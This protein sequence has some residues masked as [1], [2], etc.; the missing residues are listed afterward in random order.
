MVIGIDLGVANSVMATVKKGGV[1][2]IRNDISERVTPSLVTYTEKERIFGDAALAQIKSNIKTTARGFKYLLGRTVDDEVAIDTEKRHSLLRLISDPGTNTVAYN[3]DTDSP[4]RGRSSVSSVAALSGFLSY[5][6]STAERSV[7]GQ[8]KDCVVAVPGWMSDAGRCAVFDAAEAAGMNCLKTITE[9]GAVM[10][11]YGLYRSTTFDPEKPVRVAF[12]S[13]GHG[14]SWCCIAEFKSGKCTT[15]SAMYNERLGGRDM[16]NILID[17]MANEFQK[18]HKINPRN[19]KKAL[20]KLEDVA[21]KAKKILSA[22]QESAF[23]AECLLEECDLNGIVKRA[24]FESMCKPLIEA[25][26]FLLKRTLDKSGLNLEDISSVEVVGGCTRIPF[27]NAMIEDVFGKPVCR[28]L[29]GDESVA[30]GAALQCAMMNANFKV[31]E[32]KLID[33]IFEDIILQYRSHLATENDEP[34]KPLVI[35]ASGSEIDH[36]RSCT[37]KHTSPFE[38]F[39]SKRNPITEKDFDL[40]SYLIEVVDAPI[41]ACTR[42]QEKHIDRSVRVRTVLTASGLVRVDSATLVDTFE[43]HEP[44]KAP[45]PSPS[46]SPP[47]ADQEAP[48]EA[49]KDQDPA[50]SEPIEWVK[51]E[52]SHKHELKFTWKPPSGF[53]TPEMKLLLQEEEK[54]AADEDKMVRETKECMND[55]ESYAYNM[56]DRLDGDLAEFVDEQSRSNIKTHLRKVIDWIYDTAGQASKAAYMD[57]LGECTRLLEPFTSRRQAQIDAEEAARIAAKEAEKA[58]STETP[59]DE[60]MEESLPVSPQE[61]TPMQTE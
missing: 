61:D 54:A 26:S 17:Y 36:R 4:V 39:L 59:K 14:Q 13:I 16:D 47:S 24:D 27:V 11:D 31:K 44:K 41:P 49:P 56:S 58:A 15:L 38:I 57:K 23:N 60:P 46:P 33:K 48:A 55:L 52:I 5:L 30:R 7:I 45:T 21:S 20:L 29:H 10:L 18:A 12:V 6:R 34:L 2:V 9:H 22:N 53:L 35:F 43:F 28:T 42:E 40:G 19:N 3:F 1:S 25:F 51:K 32:F 8:I 50:E 37:F